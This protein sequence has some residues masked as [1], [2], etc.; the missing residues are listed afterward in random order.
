MSRRRGWCVPVLLISGCIGCASV[1]VHYYTLIAPEGRRAPDSNRSAI[2]IDVRVVRM[3]SVLN[4]AE[5]LVRSGPSE[6]ALLENEQWASPLTD[7]I[8]DAVRVELQNRLAQMTDSSAL[9]SFTKLSVAIDVERLETELGRHVLIE[10]AWSANARGGVD[11]SSDSIVKR[12]PFRANEAIGGGYA[13]MV[14][15]YQRG[16][17]ALADTIMSVLGAGSD[18]RAQCKNLMAAVDR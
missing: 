3:P 8:R 12:C 4:R 15:G 17:K 5:L 2:E 13:E 9:R 6:V 18:A 7:E 1:P 16:I 14:E 11:V 10:M